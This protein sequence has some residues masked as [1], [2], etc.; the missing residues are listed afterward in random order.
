MN[1]PKILVFST[2]SPFP[3]DQGDRIRLYQTIIQL[4]KIAAVRLL[5]V[6]RAWESNDIDFSRDLPNVELVPIKVSKQEVLWETVKSVSKLQPYIIYRFI[7]DRFKL[8]FQEQ[9]EIYEPDLVWGV[10]IHTYPLLKYVKKAKKV[11]DIVDSISSFYDLADNQQQVSLKQRIVSSFQFNLAEYEKKSIQESDRLIICSDP[12]LQHLKSLHGEIQNVSIIYTCV[13]DKILSEDRPWVFEEE[14]SCRLLFVG[15][16]KYPPNDLAVRYIAQEILPL[17]RS[18]AAQ[19]NL[20]VKCIICG[21]DGEKLQADLHNVPGLTFKGFVKDLV[22]EYRSASVFVSP[23][24]YATGVQNKVIDAMA[25]GLPVVMSTQ[26]ALANEMR[27][28]IDVVAC[29]RPE[30]FADAII[31]VSTDRNLAEQLAS[32]GSKLVRNRHTPA[33]Q[34]AGFQ[35]IVEQLLTN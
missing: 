29:D 3:I 35:Q 34:L 13:N 4:S 32:A 31:K 30:E 20:Q 22:E 21:K 1:K 15:H 5:Y 26:T 9:L 16:L 28:G 11:I 6:D 17:I 7:T 23:V 8:A 14:R 10:Q 33:V 27:L 25:L 12:N 19:Q 18:K 2:G 24:P